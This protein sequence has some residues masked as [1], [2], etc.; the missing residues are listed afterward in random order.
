MGWR[1]SGAASVGGG[2]YPFPDV[3]S[4]ADTT[5]LA[6]GP[7]QGRE[8]IDPSLERRNA[9]AQEDIGPNV[10]FPHQ[11]LEALELQTRKQDDAWDVSSRPVSGEDE[12]PYA[13]GGIAGD[14]TTTIDE[15]STGLDLRLDDRFRL[16]EIEASRHSAD[17]FLE[18]S[19]E[20]IRQIV[21]TFRPIRDRR[22]RHAAGSFARWVEAELRHDRLGKKEV[23]TAI[24]EN[25][26]GDLEVAIRQRGRRRGPRDLLDPDQILEPSTR[27]QDQLPAFRGSFGNLG[28]KYV[29][30]DRFVAFDAPGGLLENAPLPQE[31]DAPIE[32]HALGDDDPPDRWIEAVLGGRRT[33]EADQTPQ[34]NGYDAD[35]ISDERIDEVSI[36]THMLR[37]EKP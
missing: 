30:A 3:E 32:F 9:T 29:H 19:L 25:P 20:P 17:P 31:R 35:Q 28:V 34:Q 18:S 12:P 21:F 37:P 26:T 7:G 11:S 36:H 1:R 10:G 16:L 6:G 23:P 13:A 27:Q 14:P 8:E 4:G 2:G 33:R 24:D 22:I 5:A 15:A